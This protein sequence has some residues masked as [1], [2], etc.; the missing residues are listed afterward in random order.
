MYAD[1]I[2]LQPVRARDPFDSNLDP[3]K[4][5]AIVDVPSS[6]TFSGKLGVITRTHIKA[7]KLWR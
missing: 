3:K 4:A 2:C 1:S 7:R 5:S 6:S